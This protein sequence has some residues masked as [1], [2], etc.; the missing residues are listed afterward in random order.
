MP[1]RSDPEC[2]A[3]PLSS[4]SR[5][6]PPGRPRIGLGASPAWPPLPAVR[7]APE[8]CCQWSPLG[9]SLQA[10]D[11]V[12]D[13]TSDVIST[14]RQE[15]LPPL[16]AADPTWPA[17]NPTVGRVRRRGR[18]RASGD[19]RDRPLGRVR[20]LAPMTRNRGPAL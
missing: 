2:S 11:R 15:L 3:L 12:S 1:N 20:R 16:F 17:D 9:L 18:H 6:P 5:P 14:V 19:D 7:P 10:R 13:D 4:A 8:D